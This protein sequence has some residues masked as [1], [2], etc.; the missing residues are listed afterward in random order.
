MSAQAIIESNVCSHQCQDPRT[1]VVRISDVPGRRP[2]TA[3]LALLIA[4]LAVFLVIHGNAVDPDSDVADVPGGADPAL[5][6]VVVDWARAESSG[7]NVAAAS[8]FAIPS[9]AQNGFN[10]HIATADQARKFNASLPCGAVAE[11]AVEEGR[12]IIVTFRL[13]DKAN[14]NECG[15]GAGETARTA[16]L[17]EHGKIVEWRRV[18][19]ERAA[20][21]APSSST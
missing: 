19:D 21:S 16:F 10:F 11:E 13:G 15:A 20:P 4:A 5:V 18:A 17:I 9:F 3:V 8:Y 7:D 14:S 6:Q 12:Y 1:T 2:I